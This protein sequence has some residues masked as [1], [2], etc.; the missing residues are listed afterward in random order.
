MSQRL[1]L[2]YCLPTLGL[3]IVGL[4]VIL[5][6]GFLMGYVA[7]PTPYPV[8]TQ[9][10]PLG[11]ITSAFVH[12]ANVLFMSGLFVVVIFGGSVISGKGLQL[13]REAKPEPRRVTDL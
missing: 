9:S 3:A 12:V 8:A 11:D 7:P 10:G 5:A 2:G 1:V 13:I 4:A 6:L